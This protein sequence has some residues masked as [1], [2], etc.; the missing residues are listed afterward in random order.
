MVHWKSGLDRDW[1]CLTRTME[2]SGL[3]ALLFFECLEEPGR[4]VKNGRAIVSFPYS[5]GTVGGPQPLELGAGPTL[6]HL[7]Q[8]ASCVHMSVGVDW[9]NLWDFLRMSC[10]FC[11]HEV[12]YPSRKTR[13][14]LT[15]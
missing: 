14:V 11:P 1:M 9:F 4:L 15:G 3:S 6:L 5:G 7:H 12:D 2:C 10:V 13:P 8:E